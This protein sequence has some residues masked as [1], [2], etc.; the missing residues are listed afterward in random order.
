MFSPIDPRVW[1]VTPQ[2]ITLAKTRSANGRDGAE[3][4]EKPRSGEH[5]WYGLARAIY[6]WTDS[7]E[8]AV[9]KRWWRT[10]GAQ[11]SRTGLSARTQVPGTPRD[12]GQPWAPAFSTAPYREP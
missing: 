8:N 7:R 1:R 11:F 2:G 9:D 12:A 3:V 6:A 5:E 4:P 10:G